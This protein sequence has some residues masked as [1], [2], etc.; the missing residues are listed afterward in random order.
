METGLKNWIAQADSNLIT[1]SLGDTGQ[2]ESSIMASSADMEQAE[3]S[4]TASLADMG[5]AEEVVGGRV[6]ASAIKQA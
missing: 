4:I 3:S 1:A 2:A 6:G 5:Q